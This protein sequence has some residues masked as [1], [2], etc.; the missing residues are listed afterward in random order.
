MS[1]DQAQKALRQSGRFSASDADLVVKSSD[2]VLFNVHR[3]NL[4]MHSEGF[5]GAD[6]VTNGEI[7]EL[8]ETAE[9]L[10]LL[11]QYM[12]RQPQPNLEGEPFKIIAGLAEAAEKYRV[13]PALEI[14]KVFMKAA[15]P[16]HPT[17]VF[18]YAARHGHLN[19]CNE[20]APKSIGYPVADALRNFDSTVL[21]S[22]LLYREQW[23]KV[24]VNSLQEPSVVLHKGGIAEC[25]LWPL[26]RRH[27]VSTL[28]QNIGCVMEYAEV[29]RRAEE[30]YRL[31]TECSHCAIRA[32]RWDANIQGLISTVKSFRDMQQQALEP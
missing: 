16:T 8:S 2:G 13:F 4:E 30:Q 7:V 28:S 29:F 12:Y 27:V 21:A 5:P 11:F 25:D 18:L 1:S 19:L 31:G 23:V 32:A 24:W 6:F 17:A 3:R 15:I 20:V 14:C 9:T 10:H 26:F 22:W